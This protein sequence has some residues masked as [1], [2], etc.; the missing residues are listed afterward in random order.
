[1]T[2]FWMP[3]PNVLGAADLVQTPV[4]EGG[5]IMLGNKKKSHDIATKTFFSIYFL[6]NRL[7]NSAVINDFTMLTFRQPLLAGDRFDKPILT[8]TS[9]P[10][11]WA[12]GPVN[13]KVN[14][15]KQAIQLC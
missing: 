11:I 1:M 6:P 12:I 15:S 13:S 7:L 14:L 3:N 2:I 10:V 4:L 8:N 5:K 9:Q